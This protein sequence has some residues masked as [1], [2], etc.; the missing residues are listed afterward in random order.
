MKK[1]RKKFPKCPSC[2][3][4]LN[5]EYE[6]CCFCGGGLVYVCPNGDCSKMFNMDLK[7]V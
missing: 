4:K 7:E 3:R 5:Q 6:D 2:G 1:K